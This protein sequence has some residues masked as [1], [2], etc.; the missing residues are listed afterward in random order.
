[1]SEINYHIRV[2]DWGRD[3]SALRAVRMAV[4]V[5]EQ[6]VPLEEEW[7]AEDPTALHLLAETDD[8]APIGTA[9]LIPSGQIGRMAVLPQWRAR[10]VGSALLS[11]VLEEVKKGAYPPPF[12]NAQLH[13]VPFYRRHG[14]RE[15][16]EVFLDAGI[17]HLR[18]ELIAHE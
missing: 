2:A 15:E 3:L 10:G 17:E 7:D 4:F 14:F 18:M 8:G 6:G 11:A 9:R 16:G 13:A 1:M 12:L 5:E